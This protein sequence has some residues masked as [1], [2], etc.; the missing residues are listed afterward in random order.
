MKFI[1][2]FFTFLVNANEPAQKTIIALGK[3]DLGKK[4]T[5][6]LKEKIPSYPLF[7]GNTL[8]KKRLGFRIDNNKLDYDYKKQSIEYIYNITF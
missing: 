3:T 6:M 8:Y 1:I 4:Y 2:I 5:F 7:L